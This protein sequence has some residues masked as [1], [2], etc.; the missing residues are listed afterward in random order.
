[1]GKYKITLSWLQISKKEIK[2]WIRFYILFLMKKSFLNVGKNITM[3]L[4][5]S[6]LQLNFCCIIQGVFSPVFPKNRVFP[7]KIENILKGSLDSIP[8][9]SPL[10]KCQIMGLIT[11]SKLFLQLFEFS[12]KVKVMGSN[13]GYLRQSFLL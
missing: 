12:L 2:S 3:L 4:K 11:S 7:G 1:M 10:V 6:Q 9:P 5:S 13:P 8:S